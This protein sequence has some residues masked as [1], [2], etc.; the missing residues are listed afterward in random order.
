MYGPI[1]EPRFPK[2]RRGFFAWLHPREAKETA[3]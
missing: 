2:R 3:E 1:I